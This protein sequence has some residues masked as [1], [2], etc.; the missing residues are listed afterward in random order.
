[1]TSAVDRFK[2]LPPVSQIEILARLAHELTIV[3]RDTYH[4]SGSGVREPNRLRFL[5]EIQHR[6]TSHTLALLTS[7]PGRYPDDVLVSIIL[8]ADD[9][10]LASQVEAAF[11]RSLS[12]QAVS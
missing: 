10:E 8:G 1:M 5:N 11:D 12:L 9:P 4:I 7:D 2:S 6:V 3:G